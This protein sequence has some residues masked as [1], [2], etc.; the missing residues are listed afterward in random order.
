VTVSCIPV[1]ARVTHVRNSDSRDDLA[2]LEIPKAKS[3]SLLDTKSRLQNR[4]R[5][6][7]VRSKNNVL[8]KVHT[9]SVRRE[10]LSK[11]VKST[12]NI[13]RPLMDDVTIGISLDQSAGRCT[14]GTAHVGDEETAVRLGADL[15]DDG[16]E[17]TAVA[18]VEL[19]MVWVRSV[20]VESGVLGL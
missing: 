16:T 13:L 20:E 14:D 8:I 2:R 12:L 17:N 10:L 1:L 6:N 7:K 3:I 18:V 15:I 19:G 9:Q 11:N 4:D 5:N